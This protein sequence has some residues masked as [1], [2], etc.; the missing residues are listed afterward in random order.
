MMIKSLIIAVSI[1]MCAGCLGYSTDMPG[2]VEVE[3]PLPRV[4]DSAASG[5]VILFQFL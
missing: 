5:W 2:T 4:A 1:G 3:N